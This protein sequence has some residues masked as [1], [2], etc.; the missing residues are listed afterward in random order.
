LLNAVRDRA[1][2]QKVDMMA[3]LAMALDTVRAM[4][5]GMTG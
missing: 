3:L 4:A 1:R 2:G 5:A